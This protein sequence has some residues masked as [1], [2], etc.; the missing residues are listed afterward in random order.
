MV[1]FKRGGGTTETGGCGPGAGPGAARGP[2]EVQARLESG[3]CA[4]ARS[5]LAE[6]SGFLQLRLRGYRGNF[7]SSTLQ[8]LAHFL[9]DKAAPQ[10]LPMEISVCDTHI[11]LK[12][13]SAH[14]PKPPKARPVAPIADVALSPVPEMAGV[15]RGVAKATQTQAPP[16]RS[17]VPSS[18]EKLLVEE[19]EC[20]KVELSRAKMA[21]AEAQMEKDSLLHQMKSLTLTTS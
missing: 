9:E 7:L 6:R 4:A 18:H 16:A 11:D 5:P 20:L 19:N 1:A 14:E 2:P 15:V 13:D 21:L 12:D 10:V 3:P 17:P 8:N